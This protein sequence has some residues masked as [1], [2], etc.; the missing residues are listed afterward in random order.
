VAS[1]ISVAEALDHV[2]AHAAPLPVE[3]APL[4]EAD[5]RVLAYDLKA[6]R[7]QPPADVSA[8]DGYAVR[9]ADVAK[10]P[11][12]LKVVGEVPA[13][14]PFNATI[15]PGEAARIFT[16]G[17]VPQGA[18][19][20]VIQEHTKREGNWVEVQKPAAQGRNVRPTGLDFRAGE[21][22]FKK[23]HRLTARDLALAAGMNHPLV[24]VYRRPKIALFATGDELVPPGTEPGPG[25]IVYSNGFALAALARDEGADVA[26]LGVVH[27]TLEAAITA[28]QDARARNADILVTTGGA[29]VG[30]YDL[31]QK[32]FASE[33]MD[34]S[35]WKVAMRPGRPLMHGR[36]GAMHVLGLPGN[37][38]SSYVCAFLFLVPLMRTMIGRADL[39]APIES[40]SLGCDM[41]ANDERA[42][43]LRATLK[44]GIDGPIATP[45]PIQDSSMMLP[46][47]Q[48]NC[49]V[50]REPYAP[51]AKAGSEC[52]IVKFER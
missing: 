6:L 47:S 49:L 52:R 34:L 8:M 26:D 11:A 25:Q 7:T 5:G 3:E 33:G 2:L 9:T 48:A 10:A 18:D 20:I 14:R 36:L 30:D 44:P 12:R 17:F 51:P 35:F 40:A 32:A 31:V 46:L 42:D 19:T 28:V 4:A 22:L 41:P 39:I 43:Y 38:V 15:G 24:P 27:D 50:I 13:G 23:G 21:V 45:F 16:G 37:P 1:L 29:S